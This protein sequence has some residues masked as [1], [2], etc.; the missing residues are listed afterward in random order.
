MWPC[1]DCSR[2]LVM[3]PAPAA[4]RC[5][6][7][8]SPM[9]STRRGPATARRSRSVLEHCQIW[10]NGEP[11]EL[12]RRGR[13]HRRG[14]GAP[15]RLRGRRLMATR[16]A[17]RP[18]TSP[19]ER[20]GR[21]TKADAR[22]RSS[23]RPGSPVPSAVRG[24]LRHRGTRASGSGCS[25][26]SSRLS[27]SRSVPCRRPSSTAAR[28]RS[29][30]PRSRAGVAAT[31]P[32]T[33][34]GRRGRD[35][36]RHDARRLPRR[37]R[38][39]GSAC[40]A[41]SSRRWSWPPA[42]R[43]SPNRSIADA[44]W[45]IQCAP[46]PRAGRHVDGAARAPRPGVGDRAAAAGVG[47]R[48]RRLH[49]RFRGPE[50][51]RGTGRGADGHR[52]HHLHRVDAAD[53][54]AELRPGLVLRRHGRPSSPRSVSSSRAPCSPRRAPPP[55]PSAASTPSSS[56]P[57]PGGWGWRWSCSRRRSPAAT[58]SELER[59]AC[60]RLTAAQGPAEPAPRGWGAPAEPLPPTPP[61]APARTSIGVAGAGGGCGRGERSAAPSPAEGIRLRRSPSS[62]ERAAGAPL[63]SESSPQASDY[64]SPLATKSQSTRWSRKAV[65]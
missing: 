58:S 61:A 39:R 8:P 60:G 25:G 19:N 27:P 52:G 40:S 53:L 56:P 22:T 34:R 3:R 31:R 6:A 13:R 21:S 7:P 44:G 38:R 55:P 32:A 65:R 11:C 1:C 24:G 4:T 35:G 41:A 45:T 51:L 16:Q 50:P 57:P 48:D 49:R 10:C 26:S 37:G 33:E 42:T 64:E 59:P 36:R 28:R 46:V 12:G 62:N 54:C 29:P 43:R 23:D 47:L 20:E 15:A 63:S 9:S 14:R 18:S 5:P 2:G 17:R 30:G